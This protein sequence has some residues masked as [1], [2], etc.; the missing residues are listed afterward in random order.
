M[1]FLAFI[2]VSILALL[3]LAA[4]GEEEEGAPAAPETPAAT[5]AV[6]ATPSPAASPAGAGLTPG[7]LTGLDS[8]RYSMKMELRGLESLWAE[9]M[10]GL[11]GATPGAMPETLTLEATGAFVAP[12]KAEARMRIGG[13]EDELAMTVIGNQQWVRWGDLAMGPTE[14]TGD[15]SEADLAS[16]M[17]AG[18][19][20]EAGGLTCTSEKRE[21]VNDVPSRYCGIDKA[22]FEQLASLFGSAEEMG[23]ISELS[24]EMWLAEDGGW[25]VRLRVHVAGTDEA[26]QE[27]AAKLEMDI[28]D[29]NEKIE[30]KPPS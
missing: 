19:S 4:C 13:V 26:G 30:I 11:T 23:E 24:L 20:E 5:A 15:I 28:I 1:R 14:F 9:A 3:S 29:V 16:A 2:I 8:Y 25:P 21:T 27:V 17:W 7:S 6:T 10:G 18:F 12:D 22:T